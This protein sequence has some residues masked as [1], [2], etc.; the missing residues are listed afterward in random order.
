MDG[1]FAF[2]L[3]FFHYPYFHFIPVHSILLP[4]CEGVKV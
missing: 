3:A 1:H 4:S 2:Y